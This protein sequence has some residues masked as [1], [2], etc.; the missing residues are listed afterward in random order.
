LNLSIRDNIAYG[1]DH[2]VSDEEVIEAAKLANC[3]DFI[4]KFRSG[5][6][7]FAGSGG[8]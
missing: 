3:Y 6:D 2:E 4:M 5:F 8:C 1:A 7:T